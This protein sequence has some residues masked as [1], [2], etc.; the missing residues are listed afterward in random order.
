MALA[1]FGFSA[2]DAIIKSLTGAFSVGQIMLV[3]G[4]FATLLIALLAWHQGALRRPALVLNPL[5][6]ARAV[7]ELGATMLFLFALANMPFSNVSAILQSLPLAVTAGAAL[8]FQETVRWRRW[9]AIAIGFT[10]VMVIVRPGAEGFNTYSIAVLV[11]VCFA[12][13]RD[14]ITRQLPHEIPSLLVSTTTALGVTLAGAVLLVP[15]GGWSPMKAADI[16]FLAVAAVLLLVGYQFIIVAMRSGEIAFVA[17]FR[18]TSLL[19]AVMFGFFLFD[20]RLNTPMIVGSALIIGSGL[21]SL[22]RERKVGQ[23]KPISESTGE[24]MAPDGL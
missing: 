13:A 21:Y 11:S 14:L 18:Y 16:G 9:V 23:A 1:M 5:V 12:A 20:E 10:G 4:I 22:Y 8:F 24:G 3:R 17:P 7:C 15:L 2:N 6:A 19:W